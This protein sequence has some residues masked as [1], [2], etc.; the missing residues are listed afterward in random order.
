MLGNWLKTAILMTA[1]VA[2]FGAVGGA[3]GGS[4]G[5]MMALQS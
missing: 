2:L 1:V 3:L 4:S 5:M